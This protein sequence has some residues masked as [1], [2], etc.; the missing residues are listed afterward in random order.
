M[1]VSRLRRYTV[2]MTRRMTRRMALGLGGA[3]LGLAGGGLWLHAAREEPA[4]TPLPRRIEW[5]DLIPPGVAYSEIIAEGEMDEVND[6]WKPVFDANARKFNP[7]LEGAF[8]RMPG[9]VI[10]MSFEGTGMTEFIL[11]PYEGACIHV[12]PPPPNQLVYV[13]T[14][15]PWPVFQG[16]WEVVWVT[17][18]M[19]TQTRDTDVA[20]IGYALEA[21]EIER[22]VW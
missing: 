6:R 10:P 8:I 14:D 4:Q 3:G 1:A 20:E 12:P 18:T 9:Y 5:H 16:L 11:V 17:G 13:T 2:G 22:F 7:A 15:D 19:R 21:S